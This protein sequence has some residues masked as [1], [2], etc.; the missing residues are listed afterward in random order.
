MSLRDGTAR[1]VD[2]FFLGMSV[3]EDRK[4]SLETCHHSWLQTRDGSIIDL[5]PVGTLTASPLLV[6]TKGPRA[7]FMCWHYH[8]TGTLPERF[9][10]EEM[11]SRSLEYYRLMMLDSVS[12]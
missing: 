4:T 8:E 2:G 9:T 12:S 1:V 11:W 3:G 7:P 10:P 6:A 5:C